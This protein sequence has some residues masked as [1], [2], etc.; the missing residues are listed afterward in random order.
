MSQAW[1][2]PESA[3]PSVESLPARAD[4]VVL[5][6]GLA[7]A[8]V[9][10]F[11]AEAGTDVL[12]VE[13]RADV[14]LAASGRHPGHAL[15]GLI[16]HPY[17]VVYAMGEERARDL[18]AFS[19]ENQRLL[20]ALGLL[21]RQGSWWIALDEREREQVARSADALRRVGLPVEE[22]DPQE[23]EAGLGVQMGPAY[24]LPEDGFLEPVVGVRE[25]VRRAVER[26]GRC[27]V[28]A[29]ATGVRD[30]GD[31]V[32]VD[33]SGR[34]VRAEVVV[35]AANAWL[36][37]LDPWF[38][39]KIVPFR[40]QA[41]LTGPLDRALPGPGGRAGYGYTFWRQQADRRLVAA[42]CRWATPHLEVGER[43]ERVVDAV[44]ARIEAFVERH[45][46]PFPVE[47]RWSWIAAQTCDGLPLVGPLPGDP[48]RV[49]CAGFGGNENGLAVRAGKGVADGLLGERPHDVPAFLAATRFL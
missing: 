16:E 43:E 41:L 25:L 11:L 32:V 31:G 33:I 7:G 13:H 47:D 5:G 6:A 21:D 45:F 2:A 12:L 28:R 10:W 26:G 48:R 29:L 46:G 35:Y 1:R 14:G 42:G 40:E 34:E 39:D 17:R 4:V 20:E 9:T 27:V 30:V 3:H 23:V 15:T 8:A 22:R 36:P 44:Q 24:F 18:Y 49:A 19:R 37:E 38:V